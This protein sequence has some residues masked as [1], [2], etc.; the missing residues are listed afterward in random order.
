MASYK[1][2]SVWFGPVGLSP[3]LSWR[4]WFS[5]SG[6][7]GCA[8][9]LANGFAR[10]GGIGG[11]LAVTCAS[12]TLSCS[13]DRGSSYALGLSTDWDRPLWVGSGMWHMVEVVQGVL[14]LATF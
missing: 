6:L 12:V 5:A 9:C 1:I 14:S 7:C 13:G 4:C 2:A 8:N 3:S 11:S 10:I